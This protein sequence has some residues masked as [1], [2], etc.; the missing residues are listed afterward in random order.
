MTS[1]VVSVSKELFAA[2]FFDRMW[3]HLY[4]AMYTGM[5]RVLCGV[6]PEEWHTTLTILDND[7]GEASAK[8]NFPLNAC[9][10]QAATAWKHCPWPKAQRRTPNEQAPGC[11][12]SALGLWTMKGMRR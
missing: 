5:Y 7:A 4:S 9:T 2:S 3:L 1:L 8:L 11:Q 6:P 12:G 10:K